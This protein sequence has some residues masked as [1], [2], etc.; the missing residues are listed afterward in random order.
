MKN[1]YF[2]ERPRKKKGNFVSLM[3]S[4]K[5]I[6]QKTMLKK[7]VWWSVR[8]RQWRKSKCKLSSVVLKAKAYSRSS[9]SQILPYKPFFFFFL[10]RAE[11]YLCRSLQHVLLCM[12]Q[13]ESTEIVSVKRKKDLC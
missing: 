9:R 2:K 4:K 10:L 3:L 13:T 12:H 6:R 8:S 1:Y 5:H 11:V 7:R